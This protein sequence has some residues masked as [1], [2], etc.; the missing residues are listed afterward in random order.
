MGFAVDLSK[1]AAY[2]IVAAMPS[3]IVR[4]KLKESYFA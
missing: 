3:N 1:M 2:Q 4:S